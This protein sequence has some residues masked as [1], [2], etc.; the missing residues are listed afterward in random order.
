M[1]H[2]KPVEFDMEPSSNNGWIYTAYA[3][4]LDKSLVD[5]PS[6]C[7]TYLKC[8]NPTG[9]F[10]YDRLPGDSTPPMSRD[11]LIGM[12]YLGLE[13]H[14]KLMDNNYLICDSF[15]LKFSTWQALKALWKI[16]NEHMNTVWKNDIYEAWRLAFKILPH[17]RYYFKKTDKLSSNILEFIMFQ[18]YAFTTIIK[19]SDATG[20]V[21]A[22][23]ILYLQ[24]KH[25]NS[26]FWIRFIDMKFNFKWYFKESHF[27]YSL[28]S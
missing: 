26:K 16:R 9:L 8:N 5:V 6:L 4:M 2:D 22:K 15:V 20:K 14:V 12:H 19:K 3:K 23:N 25:L 18:L 13:S 10:I 11:E 17:D 21:S 27:F 28:I 1:F 24:L 7:I